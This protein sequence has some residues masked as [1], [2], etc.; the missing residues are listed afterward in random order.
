MPRR[1]TILITTLLAAALVVVAPT[2]AFAY[3]VVNAQTAVAARSAT[4]AV[5]APGSPAGVSNVLTAST[6][7]LSGFGGSTVSSA[8]Y[9]NT[10]ATPWS[11]VG[12]TV[13]APTSFGSG[14]ISTTRVTTVATAA[15]C[16]T[17]ASSYTALTAGA[18]TLPVSVAPGASGKLCVLT[19]HERLSLQSR[20]TSSQQ[21]IV[22]TPRWENWAVSSTALTVTTTAPNAGLMRCAETKNENATLT[23]VVPQ[24]GTYRWVDTT[25]GTDETFTAGAL[26]SETFSTVGWWQGEAGTIAVTVERQTPTG[27]A[28]VAQGSVVG[29]SSSFGFY[30]AYRCS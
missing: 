27:W 2:T 19:V 12:V 28:S 11:G 6:A 20:T 21:Q 22:V 1:H 23:F 26:E 24:D 4:F 10:G 8:V 16:P 3:W 17:A 30:T 14:S 9:T 15:T 29:R 25:T 18:A 13:T 5:S 7:D